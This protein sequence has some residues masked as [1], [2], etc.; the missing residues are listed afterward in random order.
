M[1]GRDVR[2]RRVVAVVV[3]LTAGLTVW[4]NLLVHRLPAPRAS[5]VVANAAATGAVLAVGRWAGLTSDELGLARGRLP[6]GLRWGGAGSVAVASG[7]ATALLTPALRPLLRDARAADR[8]RANL[9]F[10]ALLRIPV[11]TVV[12][13]EVAFRGVLPAV[14]TRLVPPGSAVAGSSLLFGLWHV[15]PTLDGLAANGVARGPAATTAAVAGGCAVTAGAGVLFAA[16]RLRSGSLLAP[17]LLHLAT[18][19]LG[20]LAAATV[21]RARPASPPPEPRPCW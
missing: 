20:L 16:L 17:V 6:A 7:Y 2:R 10:D 14:L 1:R 12:W 9:A 8:S 5:Y 21:Q 19:V 11:G 18:N 4:N 15:R 3:P 13:E